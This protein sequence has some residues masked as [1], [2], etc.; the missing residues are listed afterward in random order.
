MSV[1]SLL[2]SREGPQVCALPGCEVEITQPA[3]GARR[4]Y[5]SDAHR[6]AA[7]RLRK[8]LR[9][10]TEETAGATLSAPGAGNGGLPELAVQLAGVV[11]QL[12][13][14][15]RAIAEQLIALDADAVEA[16]IA[17][18]GAE[19]HERV[20]AAEAR[21]V[22]ARQAY[23]AAT[24]V[25]EFAEERRLAAEDERQAAAR[26]Q[27]EFVATQTAMQEAQAR[28]SAAE[29]HAR[30]EVALAQRQAAG[31]VAAQAAA[32]A[33]RV[34][35]A[36]AIR[37]AQDRLAEAEQ[38]AATAV[39]S[40]QDAREEVHRVQ[41]VA[42]A[43]IAALEGHHAEAIGQLRRELEARLRDVEAERDRLL[44][45][46]ARE[47]AE[48]ERLVRLLEATTAVRPNGEHPRTTAG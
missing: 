34:T 12:G 43:R 16:R 18:I 24:E 21:A 42:A 4:L 7:A 10:A 13:L 22:E 19:A 39:Q 30:E 31:E 40:A 6:M 5:C 38:R 45:Q 17:R 8:S 32:E 37:E 44:E 28:A 41:E 3:T 1:S 9:G 27:E 11:A 14:L 26:A 15:S 2:A 47:A 35:V 36:T 29:E 20:G 23:L 33:E 46:A 48:R 25:A